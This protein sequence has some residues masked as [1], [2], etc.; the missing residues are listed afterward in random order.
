MDNTKNTSAN[1]FSPP[2][3]FGDKNGT[4]TNKKQEDI[5]KRCHQTYNNKVHTYTQQKQ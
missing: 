1:Q 2:L 5:E 3:D 4:Q